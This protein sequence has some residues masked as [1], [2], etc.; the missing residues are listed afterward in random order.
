LYLRTRSIK[1]PVRFKSKFAKALSY[2][3]DRIGLRL[4]GL[5]DYEIADEAVLRGVDVVIGTGSGTFYA[6]KAMARKLGAKC[7]VVLY[8]RGYDLKS[9]DVI[10]AP[11]F[12]QPK[13]AANLIEIPANVVAVDPAFYEE[14]TE[15][16][17]RH[18]EK[19]NGRAL[20]IKENDLPI[21]VIVGGP[22]KCSTMTVEWM[23]AELDRVFAENRGRSTWVTTSR[24]TPAEVEK[25]VDSYDWDYRLIY[26]KDQFNPI[27]GFMMLAK[28]LYVTAEST[29]MLSEACTAGTAEV[30]ALD[31][32]RPGPH[33]FRRFVEGLTANGYVLAAADRAKAPAAAKKIDL[34]NEI[35]AAKRILGF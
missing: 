20:E 19:V 18:Y 22:N 29:G 17:R 30:V 7:A 13:K 6:A 4:T 10:L 24:R 1:V 34:S 16:F 21:A 33:K 31:N 2:L 35:A 23:K 12:D 14:R 8:P 26:S 25:L 28:R 5:L 15:A 3:C 11:A 27:P 32:L 9:F